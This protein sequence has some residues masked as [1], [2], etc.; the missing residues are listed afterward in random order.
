MPT[1]ADVL[2]PYYGA[3]GIPS[4]PEIGSGGL[5]LGDVLSGVT[6]SFGI[7]REPVRNAAGEVVF[8]TNALERA[9]QQSGEASNTI[10]ASVLP[11]G[12]RMPAPAIMGIGA[13]YRAPPIVQ[14]VTNP[15][16]LA[17]PG[18]Y[19]DPR[20]IAA[21]ALGQVAPEHPALRELFGVSRGDLEAIALAR[22][23]NL[24]PYTLLP[25]WKPGATGSE[26]AAGVM[27][28]Q[29]AQR[30]IDV[31]GEAMKIPE[32]RQGMVPWYVM[33]P[34]YQRLSGLVGPEQAKQIY[35]P[36]NI[37]TS[38]A[39]PGSP[40]DIELRRGT[41]ASM[42]ANQGRFD[43]FE[44]YLGKPPEKR[45]ASMAE[46]ADVPGHVYHSTS[47]AGPMAE[48]LRSGQPELQS[49]K[50]P[51]YIGAS[52]VPETGFQTGLP[53]PDVHFT[54]GLGMFDV[55]GDK[56]FRRSMQMAEFQGA[57]PWYA[58]N[59]AKPVG[60]EPVYAQALQW[61]TFA[62][63]TGVETLIGAPK[64]ELLAKSVWERA[65]RLGVD[66][67]RLM[68]Q[69]LQRQGYAALPL[70][71]AAGAGIAAMRENQ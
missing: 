57:G 44:K 45:P 9:L 6:G 43:L 61:G 67:Q 32:L 52:G 42:L 13:P 33:D 69:V 51:L 12:G 65:Q 29:N 7:P 27:N 26:A 71:G 40:V 2:A 63:Q 70:A 60:L 31:L 10:A 64:L 3:E 14:T 48:Y 41:A 20:D 59:V 38:M 55:R 54:G 36:G 35:T 15:R 22:K 21:Q 17:V 49:P 18:I 46:F 62:P 56:R 1:L 4:Y 58:Q 37:L 30:L 50:V 28:P 24:D 68:D 25:G 34:A 39:S 11:P 8:P 19:G 5:R 53:I 16:R 23:G 47:Q 66:P